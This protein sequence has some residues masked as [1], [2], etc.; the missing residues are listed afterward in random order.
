MPDLSGVDV[1]KTVR[2]MDPKLPVIIITANE[3]ADLTAEAIGQ[4]A[5][6]YVGGR[7]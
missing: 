2:R 1:L 4:G 6:S 7:L 3:D 5:F